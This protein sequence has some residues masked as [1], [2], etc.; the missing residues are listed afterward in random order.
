M[1]ARYFSAEVGRFHSVDPVGAAPSWPQSWNRY[2]YVLGN[3]VKYIDPDGMQT[4]VATVFD[5][6]TVTAA[7]SFL[8]SIFSIPLKSTSSP[9]S[10]FSPWSFASA[11]VDPTWDPLT[12]QRIQQLHPCMQGRSRALINVAEDQLN[13]TLRVSHGFR[14]LQEQASIYAQGRFGNPGP[15][16]SDAPPGRSY[17]NYGL[18]IDVA[19]LVGGQPD[20]SI[21]WNSV[22][23]LGEQ[24]G[25]EWGGR[26]TT[27]IDRTHFQLT[28]GHTTSQLRALT[29]QQ[30][31]SLRCP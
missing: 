11:F 20:W 14:S 24:L 25:F 2:G 17:H 5:E 23:T 31:Q 27:R 30:L 16:V 19:P 10:G 1:H 22:G 21:N 6:I 26:W 12:N 15:T 29:P 18:A 7:Y 13:L 3:P 28:L 4:T 8:P 9:S